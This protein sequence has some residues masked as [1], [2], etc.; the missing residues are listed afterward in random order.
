VSLPFLCSGGSATGLSATGARWPLPVIFATYAKVGA[1]AS[2]AMALAE[3]A[4]GAG[5]FLDGP[6]VG[7]GL[8][9]A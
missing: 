9:G 4:E 5:G 6:A 8:P 1:I 2:R 7:L 3:A